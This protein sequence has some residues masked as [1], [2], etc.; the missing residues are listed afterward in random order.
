MLIILRGGTNEEVSG[1]MS[2]SLDQ[3]TL[4]LPD[5]SSWL[6]LGTLLR[7]AFKEYKTQNGAIGDNLSEAVLKVDSQNE[8]ALKDKNHNEPEVMDDC[9]NDKDIQ[10]SDDCV[11]AAPDDEAVPKVVSNEEKIIK[12]D[13]PKEV[14]TKEVDQHSA[15]LTSDLSR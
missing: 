7:E 3:N 11:E 2:I 4:L 10:K 13:V 15:F 6:G 1:T 5:F 14:V 9:H 8:A 12:E